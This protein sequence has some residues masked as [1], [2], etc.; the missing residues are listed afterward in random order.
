MSTRGYVAS[1]D[2]GSVSGARAK[3]RPC[4]QTP[5]PPPPYWSYS[6]QGH[7]TALHKPFYIAVTVDPW[8][9]ET[10]WKLVATGVHDVES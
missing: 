7:Y 2:A 10:R 6:P 1:L 8:C 5:L 9:V 3:S 4:A